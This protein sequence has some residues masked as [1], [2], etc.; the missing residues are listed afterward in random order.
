[1]LP[2][3]WGR[4]SWSKNQM[5]KNLELLHFIFQY[6]EEKKKDDILEWFETKLFLIVCIML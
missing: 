6:R 1:M 4:D 3:N 5:T 2:F